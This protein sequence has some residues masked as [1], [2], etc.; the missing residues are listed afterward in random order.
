M[1]CASWR[2]ME[3]LGRPLLLKLAQ[4]FNSDAAEGASAQPLT[5]DDQA[6]LDAYFTG[7]A[8]APVTPAEASDEPASQTDA[9]PAKKPSQ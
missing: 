6:I 4:L 7:R 5:A 9:S 2:S 1:S 8:R 3:T